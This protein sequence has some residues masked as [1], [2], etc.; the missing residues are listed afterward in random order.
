MHKTSITSSVINIENIYFLDLTFV[1]IW[2][3]KFLDAL[4]EIG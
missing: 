1:K 4:D 2:P 3:Y